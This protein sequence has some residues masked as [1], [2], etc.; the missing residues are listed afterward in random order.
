LITLSQLRHIALEENGGEGEVRILASDLEGKHIGDLTRIRREG[1]YNRLV[2]CGK[3][4]DRVNPAVALTGTKAEILK[5]QRSNP[6]R[7]YT[8]RIRKGL[9]EL[10]PRLPELTKETIRSY[11]REAKVALK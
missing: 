7:A 3:G 10:S 8:D 9:M 6:S 4:P 11:I 1:W 2:A 5:R